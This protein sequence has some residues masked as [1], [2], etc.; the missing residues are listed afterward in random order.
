M[1]QIADI[2]GQLQLIAAT[3]TKD[4][5]P[6]RTSYSLEQKYGFRTEV[7]FG[8][9]PGLANLQIQEEVTVL[10]VA[11]LSLDLND[12]TELGNFGGAFDALLIRSFVIHHKLTSLASSIDLS[13]LFLS[14]NNLGTPSLAPGETLYIDKFQT[15]LPCLAGL[16]D[17]IT[18][19]NP[20]SGNPADIQYLFYGEKV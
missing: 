7:G 19:T 14:G 17:V 5:S 11:A 8:V 20:D 6:E 1:G 12:G 13:G 15:G 2:A 16:R 3:T 9:G 4:N 10:N 18:F